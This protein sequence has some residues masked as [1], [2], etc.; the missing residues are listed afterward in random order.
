MKK[1]CMI[2]AA[3]CLAACSSNPIANDQVPAGTMQQAGLRSCLMTEALAKVN[4]GSAFVGTVKSNAS[5]ITKTCLKRLALE[6]ANLDETTLTTAQ[7]ILTTAINA[8]KASK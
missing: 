8:R 2:G 6:S 7:D 1:L 4:D 5:A 3:L